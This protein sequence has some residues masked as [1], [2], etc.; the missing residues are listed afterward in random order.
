MPKLWAC[1]HLQLNARVCNDASLMQ[2]Q[3][4]ALRFWMTHSRTSPISVNIEFNSAAMVHSWTS[5]ASTTTPVHSTA[6]EIEMELRKHSH[7]WEN[8]IMCIPKYYQN[9]FQNGVDNYPLLKTLELVRTRFYEGTLDDVHIRSFPELTELSLRNRFPPESVLIPDG[10]P[11]NLQVLELDTV[12]MRFSGRAG[13]CRIR[14][15]VLANISMSRA[16]LSAFPSAFPLLEEL[17][18]TSVDTYGADSAGVNPVEFIVLNKLSK[19]RLK[20]AS[21]YLLHFVTAPALEYLTIEE[22]SDLRQRDLGHEE[23]E[24]VTFRAFDFGIFL[25]L[26]RSEA[27]IQSFSFSSDTREEI[28]FV[29]MMH[30]MPGLVTLN[31]KGVAFPSTIMQVLKSEHCPLLTSIH[32]E[33]RLSADESH[34]MTQSILEL[35]EQRCRKRDSRFDEGNDRVHVKKLA[36]PVH[37]PY[38]EE[39]RKLEAFRGA[40]VD[41]SN[42]HACDDAC[43]DVM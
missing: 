40:D 1:L 24:A 13:G 34:D 3:L 10:L 32:I 26:S 25:F 12:R 39:L 17:T 4:S 21:L 43:L 15:L 2:K 5:A 42:T 14:E 8:V 37:G 41:W 36:L 35:I 28:A 19:F 30:K 31:L 22:D 18:C 23:G 38:E 33:G 16:D 9:P 27:P 6:L 7:R 20:Q 29:L 11:S